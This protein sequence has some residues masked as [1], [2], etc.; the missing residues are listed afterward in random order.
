MNPEQHHLKQQAVLREKLQSFP[1]EVF[2]E[3]IVQNAWVFPFNGGKEVVGSIQDLAWEMEI[4]SLKIKR[5]QNIAE[6]EK[7]QKNPGLR[8]SEKMKK[9]LFLSDKFDRLMKKHED[10]MEKRYPYGSGK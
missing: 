4:A 10:L 2:V 9:Y 6:M 1:K 8:D 3:F 5:D 7:L